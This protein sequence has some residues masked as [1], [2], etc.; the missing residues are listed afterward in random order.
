[1]D[2]AAEVELGN[3]LPKIATTDKIDRG[4]KRALL[5]MKRNEHR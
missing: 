1:L 3:D 5:R 4:I 2:G